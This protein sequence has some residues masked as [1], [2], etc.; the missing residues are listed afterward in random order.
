MEKCAQLCRNEVWVIQS[1]RLCSCRSKN[2]LNSF[3]VYLKLIRVCTCILKI[4]KFSRQSPGQKMG[5]KSAQARTRGWMPHDE[6]SQNP[7]L[8]HTWYGDRLSHFLKLYNLYLIHVLF[9]FVLVHCKERT[10]NRRMMSKKKARIDKIVSLLNTESQIVVTAE[11]IESGMFSWQ[12][13]SHGRVTHQWSIKFD[14][15]KKNVSFHSE[16]LRLGRWLAA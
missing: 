4:L 6:N 2:K 11:E 1:C 8:K 13:G 15:S 14:S 9:I 10:A 16:R 12:N 5:C 3:E 7:Q